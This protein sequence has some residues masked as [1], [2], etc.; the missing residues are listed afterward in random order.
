MTGMTLKQMAA[1]ELWSATAAYIEAARGSSEDKGAF[2]SAS[3]RLHIARGGDVP[4]SQLR[5]SRREI[6]QARE[7]DLSPAESETVSDGG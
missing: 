1:A 5:A 3:L 4:R 6:I 2:V 7:A